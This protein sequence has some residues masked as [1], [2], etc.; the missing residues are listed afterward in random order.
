MFDNGVMA[1]MEPVFI[2]FDLDDTLVV[3]WQSALAAF[4][5]AGEIAAGRYPVSR[6]QIVQAARDSAREAWYDLPTIEYCLQVGISSW[7]GLWCRFLGGGATMAHLRTLAES[8]RVGVWQ[9]TLATYGITDD[10]LAVEMATT[11]QTARRARH[12]VY[13]DVRPA[14]DSLRQTYRLGVITNGAVCLQNEKL[15]G[16]GLASLFDVI[17]V[18]ADVGRAKPASEIFMCALEE[19]GIKASRAFMVGDSIHRD[20][21]GARKV[22]LR[23]VWLNREQ[24]SQQTKAVTISSLCELAGVVAAYENGTGDKRHE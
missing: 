9:K 19:A 5:A 10:A 23:A 18:S 13:N 6:E 12:I 11:F 3:E 8:Y 22:G 4:R 16:S 24:R 17:T 20:V 14:L 1:D 15:A 7:E 2:F 21:E